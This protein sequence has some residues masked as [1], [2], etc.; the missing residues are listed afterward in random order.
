MLHLGLLWLGPRQRKRPLTHT[1]EGE[2]LFERY[3]YKQ[4]LDQFCIRT[5]RQKNIVID[6]NVLSVCFARDRNY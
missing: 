3:D 5:I 2:M 6:L 1:P 4:D